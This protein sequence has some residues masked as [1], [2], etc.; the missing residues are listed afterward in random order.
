M[1]PSEEYAKQL[2]SPLWIQRKADVL[3]RDNYACYMCGCTESERLEVHHVAYYPNKKPWDYPDYLL[4]TLCRVCHQ[5]EHDQGNIYKP[6]KIHEWICKLLLPIQSSD[7]FTESYKRS[8]GLKIILPRLIMED[9]LV[10]YLSHRLKQSGLPE[11]I[12][13]PEGDTNWIN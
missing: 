9:P 8:V 5:K 2:K 1:Y 11:K 10:T 4:V 13:N 3:L 7:E 12:D 6:K